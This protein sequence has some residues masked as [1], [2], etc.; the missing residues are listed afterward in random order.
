MKQKESMIKK[1]LTIPFMLGLLVFL[2]SACNFGG[3]GEAETPTLAPEAVFTSAAQTAEAQRIER[4]AQTATLPAEAIIETTTFETPT[5]TIQPTQAQAVP[6]STAP[7]S[8]QPATGSDRGEYVADVSI[9]DGTVLAPNQTFKKT[10][11]LA[12]TGSS[13]WNSTYALVYIDGSLMGAQS[14]IPLDVTAAPGEQVEISINLT[15]PADPGSYRG[16]WKLRNA[17]GQV[18]GFGAAGE[19]AIWVDIVVGEEQASLSTEASTQTAGEISAVVLKVDQAE[20]SGGCPH[21]F[22]FTAQITLNESATVVYEIEAGSLTGSEVRVP[23]PRT[24]NLTG[25]KHPVIYELSIPL[26]LEGWARLHITEPMDFY[27]NQV[28]FSLNCT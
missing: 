26:D 23:M 3:P 20:V 18:F 14:T 19:E 16:Y 27:S 12:N 15:A 7:A 9:P 1:Y 11:R 13:T 25:G 24:Q 28:D 5:A 10:W 8:T 21:T 4:F 6:T 2:L 17:N 22:I